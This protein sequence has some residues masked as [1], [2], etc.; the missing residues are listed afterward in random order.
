MP[1]ALFSPEYSNAILDIFVASLALEAVPH[2]V[3]EAL[4]L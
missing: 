2:F 4:R 3:F 1:A